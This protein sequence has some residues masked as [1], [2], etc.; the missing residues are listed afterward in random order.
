MKP[1]KMLSIIAL[2]GLVI[3]SC[4]QT[5]EEEELG[6]LI[7]KLGD[8]E[9]VKDFGDMNRFMLGG[10]EVIR[11]SDF[12][13]TTPGIPLEDTV[14][15]GY[16]FISGSDGYYPHQKGVP[17]NT[18][19]QLPLGYIEVETRD[20]VWDT[21][22]GLPGKYN[23]HDAETLKLVRQF[24][25]ISDTDTVQVA[26]DDCDTVTVEDTLCIPL[27]SILVA[28]D[29][30][31]QLDTAAIFTLR[32]ID[33][34]EKQVTGAQ[35]ATGYWNTVSKRIKFVPDIGSAYRIKFFY[36]IIKP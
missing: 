34:Y 15:Y 8:F 29:S 13:R 33:G 27:V 23:V 5:R 31:F 21:T 30:S 16:R 2:V 11:L 1:F 28:A 24:W 19:D 26:I 36:A 7:V 3:L 22:L 35:L 25:V 17:D 6:F 32:A 12:I 4:S 18:W 20:L 10:V 14:L 9:V